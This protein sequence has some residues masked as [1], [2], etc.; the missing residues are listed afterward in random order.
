[1]FFLDRGEYVVVELKPVNA[2]HIWGTK[3]LIHE[4]LDHFVILGSK[5]INNILFHNNWMPGNFYPAISGKIKEISLVTDKGCLIM[6]TCPFAPRPP[7]LVHR[8]GLTFRPTPGRLGQRKRFHRRH[9][10]I[11]FIWIITVC[12]VVQVVCFPAFRVN[13]FDFGTEERRR[14]SFGNISHLACQNRQRYVKAR[15]ILGCIS[16]IPH[17]FN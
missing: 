9:G 4:C 1:M 2:V 5:L 10:Q 7:C 11:N 6:M 15:F 16:G 14:V 8:H 17:D 12:F 3:I 13:A